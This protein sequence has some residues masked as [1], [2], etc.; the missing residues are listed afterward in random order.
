MNIE[1]ALKKYEE[2]QIIALSSQQIS[3]FTQDYDKFDNSIT[4]LF[5]INDAIVKYGISRPMMEAADP[6]GELVEA[7]ICCAYEELCDIPAMDV[8]ADVVLESFGKVFA[9][10]FSMIGVSI[11]KLNAVIGSLKKIKEYDEA[12]FAATSVHIE[13]KSDFDIFINLLDIMIKVIDANILEITYN[14][15]NKLLN[16]N[17]F[18]NDNYFNKSKEIKSIYKPFSNKEFKRH[19]LVSFENDDG[20]VYMKISSA[21]HGNPFVTKGELGK[22]GWKTSDLLAAAVKVLKILEEAETL[23]KNLG[24]DNY[25]KQCETLISKFDDILKNKVTLSNDEKST[26]RACKACI[27]SSIANHTKLV[28][29]ASMCVTGLGNR[30]SHISNVAINCRKKWW[31]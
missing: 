6:T 21:T 13:S 20:A 9:R 4:R 12:K 23:T 24:K 3:E 27:S 25:L 18:S 26:I 7:G 16:S 10:G 11:N 1:D 14:I 15:M 17:D 19:H 8:Q 5:G 2:D 22:M 30:I 28:H 29:L 31:Y